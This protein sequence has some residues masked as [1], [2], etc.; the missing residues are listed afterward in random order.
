MV[1]NLKNIVFFK[2]NK[3]IGNSFLFTQVS[4]LQQLLQSRCSVASLCIHISCLHHVPIILLPLQCSGS[5]PVWLYTDPTA[6]YRVRFFPS[7]KFQ[8]MST[9]SHY[10]LQASSPMGLSVIKL[11]SIKKSLAKFTVVSLC[12]LNGSSA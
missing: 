3:Y 4:D 1:Q 2:L 10:A 11:H 12:M 5:P 8:Q 6:V 7:L 9:S